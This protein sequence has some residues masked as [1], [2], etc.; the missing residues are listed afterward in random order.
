MRQ[1]RRDEFKSE[2]GVKGSSG[3]HVASV[4]A[5]IADNQPPEVRRQIVELA[6]RR[7]A[8]GR[9]PGI[10]G[11]ADANQLARAIRDLVQDSDPEAARMMSRLIGNANL[12]ANEAARVI[13][14]GGSLSRADSLAKY[15]R[16][17]DLAAQETRRVEART[18]EIEAANANARNEW[19]SGLPKEDADQ[20]RN[21]LASEGTDAF[22]KAAG[23]YSRT[24]TETEA[25]NIETANA[26][27]RDEWLSGL[28]QGDA[29]QLRDVLA[30]EGADAFY[31]A[32]GE[33]SQKAA[34]TEAANAA[35][36]RPAD[37][38]IQGD[39]QKLMERLGTESQNRAT[40]YAEGGPGAQQRIGTGQV[41]VTKD[42]RLTAMLDRMK[43]AGYTDEGIQSV[44]D[45][46]Q[47]LQG[48]EQTHVGDVEAHVQQQGEFR[49]VSNDLGKLME[50]LGE[51]SHNR[52]LAYAEGGPDAER[53]IG[54]GQRDVTQDPRLANMLQRARDAGHSEEYIA[55]VVAY[56]EGLQS[57]ERQHVGNVEAHVQQQG[58]F[59]QAQQDVL[60]RIESGEPVST[61][62][63]DDLG[64]QLPPSGGVDEDAAVAATEQRNDEIIRAHGGAYGDAG[65]AA[66]EKRNEEMIRANEEI[67]RAHGGA[68]GDAAYGDA[69]VEE[70]NEEII[71]AQGGAL[72]AEAPTVSRG[73]AGLHSPPDVGPPVDLQGMYAD[74]VAANPNSDMTFEQYSELMKDL[75][76]PDPVKGADGV[77]RHPD[78]SVAA[79]YEGHVE[80][81]Q[82]RRELSLAGM[83]P[84]DEGQVNRL[85]GRE[86]ALSESETRSDQPQPARASEAQQDRQ[87]AQG[88]ALEDMAIGAE[89]AEADAQRAAGGAYGDMAV[90][91]ETSAGAHRQRPRRSAG[92]GP[93][94]LRPRPGQCHAAQ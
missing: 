28:P 1:E 55:E 93:D 33:Y 49:Q 14:R 69:G 79:S 76:T 46:A 23:E 67:I 77:Y 44:M 78:G 38:N 71:Q 37:P 18:A 42:P 7:V 66:T 31:K 61:K 17:Y 20:L 48:G 52:S 25:A 81:I 9:E 5:D 15:N 84:E 54:T 26:E 91:S 85:V 45:Y 34:E 72:S 94:R 92:A 40:A 53:R 12:S 50:T 57:G 35:S 11:N 8:S 63:L 13:L 24:A 75:A 41:D 86:R 56:A 62:E 80:R 36:E 68:Y 83:L 29:D 47:S 2:I 59:R 21:V 6:Q 73:K 65:W 43:A 74:A 3:Q 58:E 32:V 39:L 90:A 27:A 89:T 51:E 16:D 10:L 22:Y 60:R 19:L 30:S 64:F 87:K 4:V 88:G 82:A 70:R